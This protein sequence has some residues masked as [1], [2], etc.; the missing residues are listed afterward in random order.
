[1]RCTS[2]YIYVEHRC[3]VGTGVRLSVSS[4]KILTSG[5]FQP[6]IEMAE[7]TAMCKMWLDF[8]VSW[9]NLPFSA[10]AAKVGICGW[11]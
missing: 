6:Q 3:I 4:S 9:L 11:Y 7:K 10:R 1:M 8:L 5:A 2:P